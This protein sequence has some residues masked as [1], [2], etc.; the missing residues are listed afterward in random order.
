MKMLLIKAFASWL[1]ALFVL[2]SV[3]FVIYECRQPEMMPGAHLPNPYVLK[4]PKFNSMRGLTPEQMAA[5]MNGPDY[6]V[7][8]SVE[9][10]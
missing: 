8:L 2:L 7:S 5:E 6:D 4:N 10:P 9:V 1:L 3:A